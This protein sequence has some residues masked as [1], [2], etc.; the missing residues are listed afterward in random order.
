[1]ERDDV[2][3]VHESVVW[4]R[5]EE[6]PLRG[7][8]QR[9]GARWMLNKE[10]K[11]YE[12]VRGGILA[13]EVG[14]GKTFVTG[15]VLVCN[16]MRNTLVVTPVSTMMQ[17]VHE[18]HRGFQQFE[19]MPELMICS[20]TSAEHLP[21]N[22]NGNKNRIIVVSYDTL[23]ACPPWIKETKW[24]RIVLDEGHIVRNPETQIFKVLR[25]VDSFS[26][27][28]LTATPINNH[29]ND[30]IALFKVCRVKECDLT[31]EDLDE[32]T[33]HALQREHVLRRTVQVE[34]EHNPY[35]KLPPLEI[36]TVELP[37]S[38]AFERDLYDT[39]DEHCSSDGKGLAI[40]AIMPLREICANYHV[41]CR[42]LHRKNATRPRQTLT[43]TEDHLERNDD[44][45]PVASR[46]DEKKR[47]RIYHAEYKV[48]KVMRDIASLFC[49]DAG[50][51]CEEIEEVAS[52][53]RKK[54]KKSDLV[55]G[56]IPRR[57]LYEDSNDESPKRESTIDIIPCSEL[58]KPGGIPLGGVLRHVMRKHT[59]SS[60]GRRPPPLATKTRY[61]V[62]ELQTHFRATPDDKVIVF[63][64]FVDDL[65]IIRS[66]LNKFVGCQVIHG[67]MTAA[68]RGHNIMS[69][70][71][72]PNV[73]VMVAQ[74][75]CACSGINLQ[76]ANVAYIMSPTWNPCIERQ[77]IGRLYRQGQTKAVRV[78]K[79]FVK[80][81]IETHCINTQNKKQMM[82][83]N[84]LNC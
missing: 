49:R 74:V 16:T 64:S 25:L 43:I 22:N 52:P 50:D 34:A 76:C 33:L 23:R 28:I 9:T 67:S 80:D 56:L 48:E 65:N 4:Q 79:L 7:N 46:D 54:K 11:A 6:A 18:L 37:F 5:L 62:R 60:E 17:W 78:Y 83:D 70:H 45:S 27:W 77:A 82:I 30:L 61:L 38:S 3:D 63:S 57:Y 12:G 39:L 84:Q 29:I 71:T 2:T 81:T 13:D 51:D 41:L 14:M 19:Y 40:Q 26:I 10:M 55:H 53:T 21:E 69:F 20:N 32:H 75:M 58:D 31:E 59:S 8:H 72:D 1:M 36:R 15:A 68:E 73:K 24:G 66:Q 35:L 44:D 47:K 42:F